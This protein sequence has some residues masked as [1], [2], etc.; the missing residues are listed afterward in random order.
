MPI[1]EIHGA[2]VEIMINFYL[3]VFVVW[4]SFSSLNSQKWPKDKTTLIIGNNNNVK[5]GGE[6]ISLLL[7][8]F[9]SQLKGNSAL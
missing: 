5:V 1:F 8:Q 6:I 4:F 3:N 7:N 2:L 9:H